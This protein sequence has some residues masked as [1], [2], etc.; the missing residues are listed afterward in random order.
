ME[1][2]LA[3]SKL[4]LAAPSA[5]YAKDLELLVRQLGLSSNVVLNI[6]HFSGLHELL[7]TL[8]L[9]AIVP[10]QMAA[11]LQNGTLTTLPL[12][13]VA[14]TVNMIWH[15]RSDNDAANIWLREQVLDLYSQNETN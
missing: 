11:K 4:V 1:A 8:D 7:E 15:Q 5:T 9:V 10:Q 6:R 13:T 12:P 3:T 14:K 2:S